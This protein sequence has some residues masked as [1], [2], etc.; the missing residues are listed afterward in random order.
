[1]LLVGFLLGLL[2]DPEDEG[3]VF[4]K[5]VG[6]SPNHMAILSNIIFIYGSTIVTNL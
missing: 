2:F 4:L 6:P 1:M 5:K 3:A